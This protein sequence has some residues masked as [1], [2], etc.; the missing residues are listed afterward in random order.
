MKG[1][2]ERMFEFNKYDCFGTE[3]VCTY[4]N[5]THHVYVTRECGIENKEPIEVFTGPYEECVGY[6]YRNLIEAEEIMY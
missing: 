3:F 4:E 5:G 1:M 6:V 2:M